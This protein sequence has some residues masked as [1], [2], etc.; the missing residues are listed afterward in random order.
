M[1]SNTDLGMI[2]TTSTLVPYKIELNLD[3]RDMG[4]KYSQEKAG[5]AL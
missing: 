5:N 4:K 3:G 1:K 2:S